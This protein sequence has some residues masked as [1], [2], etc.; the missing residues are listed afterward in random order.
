MECILLW[1]TLLLI[2]SSEGWDH[3]SAPWWRR[4]TLGSLGLGILVRAPSHW[5]C[6]LSLPSWC[7]WSGPLASWVWT[8]HTLSLSQPDHF[9]HHRH[10]SNCRTDRLIWN[11]FILT[12][13]E[14]NP[15]ACCTSLNK[16]AIH[17]FFIGVSNST[18]EVSTI[19]IYSTSPPPA[20]L[21]LSLLVPSWWITHYRP[22]PCH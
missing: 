8:H 1:T 5:D 17:D 9:L 10:R 15:S 7:H 16:P 22:G 4:S 19:F 21:L 3:S 2:C 11:A 14:D 13:T 6:W 12:C 18:L 20:S